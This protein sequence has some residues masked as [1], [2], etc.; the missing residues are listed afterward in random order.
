[1]KKFPIILILILAALLTVIA[2]TAWGEEPVEEIVLN[3]IVIN[4]AA[5]PEA[6]PGFEFPEDARLLHIWFP[7]VLNADEAILVFGDQV[8][9]IDCGD[10][11]MGGRGAALIQK[12][13]IETVEKVINTHPHHDHL[14]GLQATDKA[15]KVGE[16]AVCFTEENIRHATSRKH[17]RNAMAYAEKNEIAVTSYEEGSVFTMGEGEVTLTCYVNSEKNLDVNNRSAQIMLRYGKRS[18]LFMADME[19]PGQ[20]AMLQ[21]VPTEELKAD[22]LK[23]PHHGKSAMEDVFLEAVDPVAAIITNKKVEDWN[24][25][26]YLKKKKIPY[27]YTTVYINKKAQYLH[28]VTDGETWVLERVGEDKLSN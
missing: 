11:R 25:I 26:K 7:N 13:G 1:M 9:L 3:P 15:A 28:L 12:L 27:L 5:D 18:I 22:L 24:G 16:L 10:E 4:R 2:G 19:K 8:W 17:F 14:N 23:Y 20:Q 6:E 21:R